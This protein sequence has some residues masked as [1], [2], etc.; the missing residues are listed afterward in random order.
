MSWGRVLS[1]RLRLDAA[2]SSSQLWSGGLRAARHEEE[3]QH[4][5]SS[6]AAPLPREGIPWQWSWCCRGGADVQLEGGSVKERDARGARRRG[7][8]AAS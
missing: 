4:G 3:R 8:G 5:A 7:G 6:T 1:S 2:G